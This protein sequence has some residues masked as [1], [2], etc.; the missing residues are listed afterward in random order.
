[1]PMMKRVDKVLYNMIVFQF[2]FTLFLVI[3]S[4]QKSTSF[5]TDSGAVKY[6]ELNIIK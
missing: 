5:G 2:L 1:M 6:P 3:V 4:G